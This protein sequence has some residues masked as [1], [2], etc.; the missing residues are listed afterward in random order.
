MKKLNYFTIVLLILVIS[1]SACKTE[2]KQNKKAKYVFLFIGDG[3]GISHAFVTNKY[4]ET[5]GKD[6]LCFTQFPNFALTTTHCLDTTK[7]TDSAASGTA[8][9]TGN[10]TQ[11]RSLGMDTITKEEF[12]SIA[13]IA[14]KNMWKVGIL[15]SVGL[16]HA[17]PAAFYGNQISRGMYVEIAQQMKETNFDLFAGG[18]IMTHHDTTAFEKIIDGLEQSG[19]EIL[20]EKQNFSKENTYSDKLFY[21]VFDILDDEQALP[22]SID[23]KDDYPTLTD[24]TDFAINY[25]DNEKG[26]FMMVEGGKI[27]WACHGNDGVTT[28][29]EIIAFNQAVEVALDFYEKYPEETLII[30]TADHETGGFSFGSDEMHYDINYSLLTKQKKSADEIIKLLENAQ[31]SEYNSII[32]ENFSVDLDENYFKDKTPEEI[33]NKLKKDLNNSA[34]I[35]WT[36]YSHTGTPVGTY[37]IGAGSELFKGVIDNTDIIKNIL[38][39]TELE[40]NE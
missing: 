3:M 24:F 8:I 38:E 13:E 30:V 21:S 37:A 12:T 4:L 32:L 28:I 14:K 7:V 29:N 19:Y 25:L 9:A 10:K 18:G 2:Q 31:I 5:I 6:K 35:G 27:D 33:V 17:T 36:T 23:Y 39:T 20:S 16:N 26:F 22:Y 40:I 11:F 34:G 1:L 15:S